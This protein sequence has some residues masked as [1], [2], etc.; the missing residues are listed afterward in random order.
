MLITRFFWGGFYLHGTLSSCQCHSP[1]HQPQLNLLLLILPVATLSTHFEP[2]YT[3]QVFDKI[4]QRRPVVENV[5]GWNSYLFWWLEF[6][7]SVLSL[8]LSLKKRARG[9]PRRT[10]ARGAYLVASGGV[11]R[12]E[13]IK[14]GEAR[15]FTRCT[16]GARRGEAR[17]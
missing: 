16:W 11:R 14:R 12:G 3:Q 8:I 5:R 2:N 9:A 10:D 1:S 6:L 17:A 15:A 7:F 4:P 13:S